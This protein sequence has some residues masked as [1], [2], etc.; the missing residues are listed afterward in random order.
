M[1]AETFFANFGH[2][3]DAPN[4]VKKLRELILQLAVQGK[5][6]PQD[7]NDEPVSV[8]LEKVEAEKKRLKE[9]GKIKR[10]PAVEA[11]KDE[12]KPFAVPQGW[13]W[14]RLDT[15]CSYIQRGKG[16]KY[17]E[18]SDIPVVSQK[19]V[20]WAGFTL[21]PARYICPSTL[22]KYVEERFLR[23]GDLLWN[24]TGTG[25]IGR[26]NI[27]KHEDN[28]YE[29]VVADS[30]VTVVRPVFLDSS[31]VW[32]WLASPY[33]QADLEGNAS[34]STNQVELATSVVKAHVIPLPPLEEQKRIV[35]KVDQLMAQ[36]DELEAHQKKQQQGRVR[37]NNAA[38]DAL[39]TAREPDEFA[40]HWQR[41]STNFDLLYDHPATI[42]KLRAAIL[43]LAVQGKLVPQDLN[44]EP[45]SILLKRIKAE[46]KRLVREGK[47]KKKKQSA[48]IYE[49]D[50]P[51]D[52]PDGIAWVRL[53]D[54][55]LL[56]GDGLHG[57]PEYTPGTQYYFVNGN[58]LNNGLIEI[59]P[60]TKS[61]SYEELQKHKKELSS[62]SVLVSINGTLGKVAFYNNEEIML[63]KSA[64]YFN[65]N[66]N[67]SKF[68]IK[69][70]LESPYWMEYA[71]AS[72]TGS[73][74][75]N[76]GL[77]AMNSL[78]VP[79]PPVEEQKR[80]VAKVDQL[81]TLCDELEAKLN[82]TQQ[83][84]AKLMEATVQQLLVA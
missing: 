56:L 31:Y 67:V 44:D 66:E 64:C 52:L 42:A 65:L 59:K 33:I 38:L 72:A 1:T 80:I 73:T 57:T 9:L 55:V 4:G 68:Y 47:I 39:L 83:H 58:N 77:K 74:I 36:C 43:Q 26:I 62:N 16:P 45:V 71:L 12:E 2:L 37:L 84:S 54:L 61:V 30:H 14:P 70:V 78:P 29:I 15:V 11:V 35:A 13:E 8:F 41:I 24:S 60:H 48:A 40:D 49:V 46:N 10:L 82:Q 63:G 27:Y 5:L 34:G 32:I 3:A 25:T 18:Q 69:I 76:L 21:V 20:Q 7:V 53:Q 28:P 23:S 19:C 79:L 17:V 50:K 22:E 6:V 81:M 51:F 75:K